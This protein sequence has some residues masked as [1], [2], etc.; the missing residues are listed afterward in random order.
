MVSVATTII[1][2]QKS[3]Y[4][5]VDF[6]SNTALMI[7]IENNLD[8][9]AKLIILEKNVDIN[10]IKSSGENALFLALN[11]YKYDLVELILNTVKDIDLNY[12]FP[13]NHTL[14]Y[15]IMEHKQTNLA[16]KILN[17]MNIKLNYIDEDDGNTLLMHAILF[18]LYEI[19]EKIISMD[20]D[21]KPNV[22][23]SQGK[24]A[25]ILMCD[26]PNIYPEKIVIDFINKFDQDA[27]INAFNGKTNAL[28]SAALAKSKEI[29]T[30]LIEKNADI[31]QIKNT[32]SSTTIGWSWWIANN[33]SITTNIFILLCKND[34]DEMFFKLLE[35]PLN[36][37][38]PLLTNLDNDKWSALT[39]AVNLGKIDIINKLFDLNIWNKE[40]LD[41][42]VENA[43][44]IA[45]NKRLIPVIN[46][47]IKRDLI[48]PNYVSYSSPKQQL[49]TLACI[50]GLY[51]VVVILLDK[52]KV[53]INAVDING[54][55]ALMNTYDVLTTH[56]EFKNEPTDDYTKI[57]KHLISY[58]GSNIN[59]QDVLGNT[60]L[61]LCARYKQYKLIHELINANANIYLISNLNQSLISIL[62]EYFESNKTNQ[63]LKILID[64]IVSSGIDFKKFPKHHLEKIAEIFWKS[65]KQIFLLLLESKSFDLNHTIVLN[66][67]KTS[68]LSEFQEYVNKQ[69]ITKIND[70][71][72]DYLF[73][74]KMINHINILLQSDEII[75]NSF[76]DISS[77]VREYDDDQHALETLKFKSILNI[78]TKYKTAIIKDD[79]CSI[80]CSN[81]AEYVLLEPC[82]HAIKIDKYCQT[83]LSQCPLCRAYIISKN[84]IY[85]S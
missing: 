39:H 36:I 5:Q 77:F 45:L 62:Y 72:L 25:L 12:I 71:I 73:E 54:K 46:E 15:H 32:S 4:N 1:L 84:I 48:D 7:A 60:A 27:N 82:K 14:F 51:D 20:C 3:N 55:T 49:L 59:I 2:T 29:V 83:Q 70:Q 53:D 34:W 11:K 21:I 38:K 80:C 65:D 9:I 37:I 26:K 85:L 43:F 40:D 75:I 69:F 78:V 68:S 6:S 56:L 41:K 23:N 74:S 50:N 22:I 24:T 81:S 31:S 44:Q 52:Y 19:V 42:G 18:D 33:N 47:F 13:S 16:L 8:S 28:L 67:C 79:I 76:D 66:I 10:A 58:S 64:K 61:T 57:I 30:L 63:E 35:K 17:T